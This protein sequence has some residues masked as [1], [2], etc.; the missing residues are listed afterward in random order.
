MILNNPDVHYTFTFNYVTSLH[1][2][3]HYRGAHSDMS[4]FITFTN[5]CPRC[6]FLLKIMHLRQ[7]NAHR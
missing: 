3:S 1:I 5:T 7:I 2:F 4:S 6:S